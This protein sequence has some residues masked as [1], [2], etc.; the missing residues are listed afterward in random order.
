VSAGELVSAELARHL[1]ELSR[2]LNR[3]VGVLLTRKGEVE[4][5]IVGDAAR[6]L[7]PDIGRARAGQARLR[8]LR[9]IHTHLNEEP[10]SRD[11]LTDLALLRLDA[12]AAI[13]VGPDGLPGKVFVA[14]LLPENARGDLWRIAEHRSV[15]AIPERFMA[16]IDALAGELAEAARARPVRGSG[17]ALLVVVGTRGREEAQRSLHELRE[18]C[19]T[20]GV[21]VADEVVQVRAHI[22]PRY[23]LGRGKLQEVVLRSMQQLADLLVFD[24]DLSPAQARALAD[25]TELKILDRT[26]LILD[27]FAQR[28]SSRDGRLQVELA[29]LR[30]RLPRLMG[31]GDSLSR[32]AGGIGGRGPGETK[33]EI[34]RRRVRERIVRLEREIDGLSR[35]RG[36][37]RQ[38]RNRRGLPTVALVGYTNAGKST[39]LNAL[40]FGHTFVE[41]K[42][43][44]TLDP[45][46][47]KLRFPEVVGPSEVVLTDTVGFLRDLPRDL[48]A[49]FR[50]TL[51][52][53][54]EADLLV[55]V[56]DAAD[57]EHEA[58]L[59]AV[60]DLLSELGLAETPRLLCLNK[61][62][63]RPSEEI[64]R[65]A[66]RLGGVAVSAASGAGL[67]ALLEA[68]RAKLFE[69]LDGSGAAITA[70]ARDEVPRAAALGG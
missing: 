46:T 57:P 1:T 24:R 49:A 11:D 16:Q 53:L 65:T 18:L 40:T 14:H 39:L 12:V 20:A 19:R 51:E 61:S 21:E 31:K 42:L 15:H 44:A 45:K 55:L 28:A 62:D 22:D 5:V 2:E 67:D 37:R 69:S 7:L 8:G 4:W 66:R 6:L 50:A 35:M 43:F 25:E 38:R 70:Q 63:L 27:I 30:Y 60:E 56:L 17:R 58:K 3:Q 68:I 48:V 13:G 9:L 29:Q 33:L 23:V 54:H 64:A 36:L 32:L 41:D 34:D 47:R 59:A 10:L 26:Q 52:E